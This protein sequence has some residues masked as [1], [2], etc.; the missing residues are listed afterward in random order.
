MTEQEK[1]VFLRLFEVGRCPGAGLPGALRPQRGGGARKHT[2][3]HI[4][5][6]QT[7]TSNERS[8]E[9]TSELQSR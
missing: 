3:T 9:H 7:H 1:P 2:H 8:E 6:L 5:V 4:Q